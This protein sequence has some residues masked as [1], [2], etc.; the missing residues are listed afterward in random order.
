[1]LRSLAIATA[2]SAAI[3]PAAVRAATVYDWVFTETEK[4]GDVS[5]GTITGTLTVENGIIVAMTG[6]NGIGGITGVI[7]P[8]P[9]GTSNVFPVGL[10]GVGFKVTGGAAYNLFDFQ[11]DPDPGYILVSQD[12]G[13]DSHGTFTTTLI[14]VGTTI[15]EPMSLALF[16]LG[17]AGIAAARRRAA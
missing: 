5:V 13:V 15:P 17:L 9:S 10:N 2:L 8:S 4:F 14:R 12:A 7:A 3:S 16:G 11:V 1:M 6:G